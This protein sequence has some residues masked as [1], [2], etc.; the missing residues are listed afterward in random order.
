M[1]TSYQNHL[2]MVVYEFLKRS[3]VGSP[4]AFI[5]MSPRC[6]TNI[7]DVLPTKHFDDLVKVLGVLDVETSEKD[8]TI[9][10]DHL[11]EPVLVLLQRRHKG[12]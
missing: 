6:R 5:D 1:S 7:P 10:D 9:L 4:N 8:S 12:V 3:L 2:M 11:L